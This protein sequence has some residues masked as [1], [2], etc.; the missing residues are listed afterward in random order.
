M[1]KYI[2]HIRPCKETKQKEV[3][4]LSVKEDAWSWE[5]LDAVVLLKQNWHGNPNA[6]CMAK[7]ILTRD[8]FNKN[9][10]NGTLN[11]DNN[12]INKLY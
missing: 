4:V 12:S 9:K 7:I 6:L 2:A 10:L 5:F 8:V 11:I 3:Y 1:I